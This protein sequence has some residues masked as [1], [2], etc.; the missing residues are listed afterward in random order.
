MGHE[1]A[2]EWAMGHE[3]TIEGMTISQLRSLVRSIVETLDQSDE[4]VADNRPLDEVLASIDEHM[5]RPQ[6]G[7]PS[8]SEMVRDDRDR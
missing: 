6:P 3:L 2:E 8:V 7:T 1:S 4:E 5:I